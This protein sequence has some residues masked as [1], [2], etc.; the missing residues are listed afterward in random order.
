MA[1]HSTDALT[2][3]Q[4]RP[5]P[6]AAR[7]V[8]ELTA[9]LCEKCP[10]VRQLA[11]RM[12]SETGTRLVD[13][14]DHFMCPAGEELKRRLR[15]T[16]F[17][18]E[19][20]GH[21]ATWSHPHGLFPRVR[22]RDR[23]RPGAAIKVDSVSD[24]VEAQGLKGRVEIEGGPHAT[25]RRARVFEI[26]EGEWWAFERHGG[27]DYQPHESTA[28]RAAAVE[29]HRRAFRQRRRDFTDDAEGFAHAEQLTRDAVAALGAER[30]SDLFFA[31]EREYWQS[32]NRAAQ[33]QKARQDRLGLGWGNHDHHTYRSSREHF[34]RL[35]ALL[36]RLGLVCRE[37]F[38]AGSEA[39]W[40]AQVLE[41][42]H[43][44]VVVF[45]DVDLAPG[46]VAQDFA[47]EPLTPQK[48]LGTVGLWCRLHGEAALPAGMHHLEAQFDFQAAREQLRAEGIESMAPF[49]DFPYLKQCFTQGE[50][51]PVRPERI[52]ALLA[53]GRIT[54]EQAEKFRREGAIGS[55]LEILERNDGYK[56]FNQTGVSE[57]IRAT[58]PR[59]AR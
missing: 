1:A 48:E 13:W 38:Y 56:G 30:A 27:A 10:P 33:V 37:R 28:E 54:P 42:P 34:A 50:T 4:W 58:D 29:Q 17:V 11:E 6:E 22:L 59:R 35:I 19:E 43:S 36:E 25:P 26:D 18:A 9:T 8:G 49:T 45:A 57:I 55:H 23:A 47:H 51:W 32:R 31:A 21:A 15:E 24:F 53:E 3:F 41:Q 39:G 5:Q 14:I 44:G 2:A 7:L 46:E 40:G 16:G 52:D 20:Q 12:R